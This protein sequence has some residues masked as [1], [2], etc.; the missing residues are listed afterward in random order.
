MNVLEE[1]YSRMNKETVY[2]T[3]TPKGV[4]Y[5]KDHFKQPKGNLLS[6]LPGYS[7]P[8]A[9]TNRHKTTLVVPDAHVKPGEDLTRF[10][11]LGNL[12]TDKKPDHI[13]LMGDFVTLESLSAWDLGKAGKMEGKRYSEDCKAGIQAI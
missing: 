12:I 5:F 4:D 9:S 13:V 1:V 10:S 6:E 11:K 7:T 2:L 3:S 8:P